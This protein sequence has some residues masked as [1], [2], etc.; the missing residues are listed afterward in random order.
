MAAVV[1][2][3]VPVGVDI[4]LGDAHIED[5]G[6]HGRPPVRRRFAGAI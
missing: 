5:G 1:F 3:S 4:L 2:G 6:F